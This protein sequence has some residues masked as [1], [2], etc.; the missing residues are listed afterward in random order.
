MK[1]ILRALGLMRAEG[2]VETKESA[3]AR[4]PELPKLKLR[5]ETPVFEAAFVKAHE[6]L[7]EKAAKKAAKKQRRSSRR[8]EKDMR[9]VRPNGHIG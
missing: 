5:D 9:G 3:P 2:K 7:E 4:K 6:R 1:R 8:V